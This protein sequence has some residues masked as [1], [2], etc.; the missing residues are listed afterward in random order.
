MLRAY[1]HISISLWS[2]FDTSE[3]Y[4]ST[5]AADENIKKKQNI[6]KLFL[7]EK[8]FLIFVL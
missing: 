4:R 6:G 3:N 1:T 5:V 2:K 7:Y 8:I